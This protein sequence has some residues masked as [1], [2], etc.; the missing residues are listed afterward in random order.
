M[1]KLASHVNFVNF[2]TA[3][4]FTVEK[5]ST[6]TLQLN[7]SSLMWFKIMWNY[8]FVWIIFSCELFFRVNYYFVWIIFRENYFFVR[9][10]FSCELFFRK[11]YFFVWIIFSWESF[12]RVNYFIVWIIISCELF[13]VRIIFSW[14][15]FFRVNYFFVRIIFSCELF[16]RENYFFV[17]IVKSWFDS[18]LQ[19]FPTLN[20]LLPADLHL[21]FELYNSLVIVKIRARYFRLA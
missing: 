19:G 14:E 10:I 1:T 12:Y 13:F 20:F 18:Q 7:S 3:E 11:N 2:L 15:L 17:W 8:F 16:F 9:I 5:D 21:R 6:G 4:F